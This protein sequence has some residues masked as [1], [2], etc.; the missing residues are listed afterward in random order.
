MAIASSPSGNMT[1]RQSADR[2]QRPHT[3]TTG[4]SC[5]V[6]V[7]LATAVALGALCG[8]YGFTVYRADRDQQR[9]TE[10]VEAARRA[11]QNLTTIGHTTAES[12]VRRILDSSTAP[13]LDDFQSRSQQFTDL[14]K[15]AKT[16]SRGTVTAA[17][18][19]TVAR[20]TAT[21]L[22]AVTVTMSG[23]GMPEETSR[24]WRMRI[25]VQETKSGARAADVDFVV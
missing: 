16:D 12:D 9:A 23:P 13:F 2:D 22:V 6:V 18:L 14:V 10:Y 1:V 25:Q 17:G 15:R 24:L 21:V 7:C 3:R 20:D 4:Q 5:A 19:E 11:A 8:G